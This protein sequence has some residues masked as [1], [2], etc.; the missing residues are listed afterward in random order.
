ML[1]RSADVTARLDRR[2]HMT[3]HNEHTEAADRRGRIV[4]D[5]SEYRDIR[6]PMPVAFHRLELNQILRVYGR[7]VGE[8]RIDE[9][10]YRAATR[11]WRR[12]DLE[13]AD[14]VMT[15]LQAS[16]NLTAAIPSLHTAYAA[17]IGAFLWHGL[18]LRG[19]ILVVAYA[20]AM[21][22]TLVLGAEH[23]MVDVLIG[24]IYVAL[25]MLG[26]GATERWWWERRSAR[27]A[28]GVEEPPRPM[29]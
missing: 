7:M 8:G 22:F 3:D 26:V 25:V 12:L 15:D 21:G 16:A 9:D 20:L 18:R 2:D 10:L 4:I 29:G 13:V 1:W 14:R 23:Y 19:R 11:G 28:D 6:D 17:L 24:W 5:L 27:T